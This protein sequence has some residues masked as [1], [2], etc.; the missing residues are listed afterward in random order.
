MDHT[1]IYG[2]SRD[3]GG[4]QIAMAYLKWQQIKTNDFSE[5]N[6]NSLYADGFL[7]GRL[8]RGIMDQ[9]RSV[10]IDLFDFQL[11][12]ENRRILKKTEGVEITNKAL[13]YFSYDWK[14]G[15]LGKDFY[16]TKFGE[17][18]F[19]ANKLKELLTDRIKSNFN[20]LLI[21][22]LNNLE[23]I[24]GYAICLE[25]NEILHYSYPFYELNTEIPNLGIGMMLRAILWA[26]ETNK[27]Y[28]YLGSAQRPSDIYKLQFEGLEWFDG[29][30]WQTD[31]IK[32]KAIL[33]K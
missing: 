2:N 19:S 7:F 11:S 29:K 32:L 15:K 26:Q 16:D 30:N 18:T 9:T 13:P 8:G 25:T 1:L 23:K 21:Y 12:S 22:K 24:L 10:R 5:Q 17:K 4:T 28:I 3:L 27:R 33:A 31:L 6:I 20:K 14:I